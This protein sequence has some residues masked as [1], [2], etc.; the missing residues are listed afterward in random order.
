MIAD[1]RLHEALLMLALRDQKGGFGH[2]PLL[3][4]GLA[5]AILI[6]LVLA[7]RIRIEQKKRSSVVR[8]IDERLTGEPV[9]DTWLSQMRS[10]RKEAAVATWLGRI[11]GTRKLVDRIAER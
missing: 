10:A 2:A 5:G 4:A 6:E 7:G 11:A 8:V 9:M 3:G 1:L